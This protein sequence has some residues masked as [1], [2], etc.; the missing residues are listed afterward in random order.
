M[1]AADSRTHLGKFQTFPHCAAG[2]LNLKPVQ[3]LSS[4]SFYSSDFGGKFAILIRWNAAQGGH[5]HFF[6][7]ESVKV[8]KKTFG[9]KNLEASMKKFRDSRSNANGETGGKFADFRLSPPSVAGEIHRFRPVELLFAGRQNYPS[10][11]VT[12]YG[13]RLRIEHGC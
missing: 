12:T 7:N 9:V 8:K 6:F 13:K 1:E 5:P 11:A 2:A 3:S 4:C 10:S